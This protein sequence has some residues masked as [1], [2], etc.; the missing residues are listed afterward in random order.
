MNISERA[1]KYLKTLK[2]DSNFV[3]REEETKEYLSKQNIERA[4]EFLKF[5]IQYSGYELTINN[6]SG[7]SF[8]ASLFSKNQIQGNLKLEIEKAGDRFI[9][10]CGDHK[11]AQF[12]FYL[13]DKGEFCTLDDDDLPNILHTSFDKLIE[14]YALRNEISDWASNP[15]YHEIKNI[16]RLESIMNA[17]FE[18]IEECSD[19]YST[20]WKKDNLIAVKGIW[21]DR[22]EFYFHIYGKNKGECYDFIEGLKD[23]NI[24]K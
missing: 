17:D 16:D 6:D 9:E 2:R 12:T 4:D 8:S 18:I 7:N 22:P 23:D 24:L 13:T 14:E 3:S 19:E 20:W 1:L 5:Q 10:I 21:L 11:T 15:Y